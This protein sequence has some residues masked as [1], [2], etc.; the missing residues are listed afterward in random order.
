MVVDVS[1]GFSKT[2]ASNEKITR[3]DLPAAIGGVAAF[4]QVVP[5]FQR[6]G[7]RLQMSDDLRELIPVEPLKEL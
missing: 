6:H 7:L 1:E 2:R 4:V 3:Q 5:V